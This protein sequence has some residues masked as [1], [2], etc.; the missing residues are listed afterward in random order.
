MRILSGALLCT[1]LLLGGPTARSAEPSLSPETLYPSGDQGGKTLP[2]FVDRSEAA[3]LRIVTYSGGTEKNHI[4]ESS[5]NGILVLDYDRDGYPD[6][7][8][9]AAHRLAPQEP[10]PSTK[11]HGPAPPH[12]ESVARRNALQVS[13][14]GAGREERSALYHNNG[15]GTFTDV[16]QA[17]GVA[18][19]VY[20][21]GGCVGDVDGDG[22]PDIYLTA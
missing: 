13:P 15:D 17:A 22:L 14:P 12:Q 10:L 7:Y 8:F 18:A 21:H 19:R 9:V 5:G 3:G 1:G 6:L 16:T 2:R 20:G 11:L 4:L